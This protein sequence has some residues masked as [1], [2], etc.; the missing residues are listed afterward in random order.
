MTYKER[1]DRMHD[2]KIEF[3]QRKMAAKGHHFDTI[4]ENGNVTPYLRYTDSG[5]LGEYFDVDDHGFIPWDEPIYFTPHYN[6][7]DGIAVGMRALGEN[8]RNWLNVHP[9]YMHPQSALAGAWIG[10]LPF[11]WGWPPEGRPTHLQELHEKYNIRYNG[12]GGMNH[13]GPDMTIGLELG[14]GGL[15]KKIRFYRELNNPEDTSF[16]DGEEDL[17]LGVQEFI[18]RHVAEARR[19]AEN[20]TD[21]ETKQ[22]YVE[23][24]DM[25][26]WLVENPPRT[27]REACQFLAWFQSVDRMLAAGGAL[28]ELDQ[29]LKPYYE[30]EKAAGTMDFEQAK[31]IVAS[32]FFNDTHYSQVGGTNSDGSD[33]TSEMSFVI[34]EAMHALKIPTNIAVRVHD[35]LNPDLLKLAVTKLF[36]DGTGADYSMAKGIEDGYIKNGYPRELARLRAKVGCNWTALPGVEYC[37]QDVTRMCLVKPFVFALNEVFELPEEQRT[38]DELW[39][40]YTNHLGIAVDTIKRGFDWHAQHQA[41][42]APEIVLNLFCHGPVERG[43]DCSAGGVDIVNFTVD[44][45]GLATVADSL[46]AIEQRVVNEKRL[47]WDELKHVLDTNYENAEDIRLMLKNIDRY[48][49]G[50]SLGDKWAKKVSELYT[51]LVKGSPLPE[52][53]FNIIPGLFSHG[54]VGPLGKMLP[55]TPNGRFAGTEISHNA[56][57]DPGFC[58]DGRAAPTA[59]A[60]A[61]AMTQPGYGNSAPLQIELDTNLAKNAG[62]VDAVIAMI[63]AHNEMRGTLI[64]INVLSREKLLDAHKDPSKHPDLVVR[65]TGYSAFFCTLSPEYRQQVVDRF[66]GET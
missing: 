45:V 1:I 46:A 22:N 65:V 49:S 32:L 14:W 38:M 64:N 11:R 61:V 36:E 7:P 25:N 33:Q 35:N 30:R 54:I 5:S 4:D 58:R 6:H 52:T 62:G 26:E 8:F 13:L 44:G 23:L 59:K 27:L 17:V 66:L 18:R 9:V 40:R 42:Y 12:I 20:E 41:Q 19:L 31:W 43:V 37:L 50:G 51:G 21:P 2:T 55:A 15:L 16:Y 56:E 3:T 39:S 24:A 63:K 34:I 60:A 28:G 47:S 48:G 10:G 53:H 29:L 57:P